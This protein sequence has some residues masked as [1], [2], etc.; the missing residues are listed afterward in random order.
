MQDNIMNCVPPQFIILNVSLLFYHEYMYIYIF[1]FHIA[2]SMLGI[3]F[4]IFIITTLGNI[5]SFMLP[6]QTETVLICAPE[7]FSWEMSTR[8]QMVQTAYVK[9]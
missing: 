3:I 2:I 8:Q 4:V 5:H 6:R 1:F 9:L 7:E